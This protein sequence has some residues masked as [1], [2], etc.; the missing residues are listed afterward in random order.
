MVDYLKY[1]KPVLANWVKYAPD[2]ANA[3]EVAS[4]VTTQTGASLTWDDIEKFRKLWP[5]NF[6]LKG[7]MHPDDA[8]RAAEL[9]VDG[10]MV[11]NHGARQL[12]RAPAPLEVFP[13][14]KAAVGNRMTLMMDGGFRRGADILVAL[15]LGVE[16]IF[17]GRPTL[18]GAAAGGRAGASHAAQI[19]SNEI[20]INMR[21]M[22]V[23]TL[24]EL[25]SEFLL[26]DD[27]DDLQRNKR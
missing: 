20:K 12:D 23:Q 6:V 13:A 26:W 14:I 22:G 21:Q 25:G 16:F 9:G 27:L 15:C 5:R 24:N 7:V 19:F 11:S 8:F 1:G 17:M 3:D 2:G 18:Y 10:L 4:F